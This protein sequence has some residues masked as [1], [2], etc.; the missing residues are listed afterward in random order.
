M[1]TQKLKKP[2]FEGRGKT[3]LLNGSGYLWV[4][5]GR[6]AVYNAFTD[7]WTTRSFDPIVQMRNARTQSIVYD[8]AS[9]TLFIALL[10]RSKS[11][12]VAVS[13]DTGTNSIL[14]ADLR[15]TAELLIVVDGNLHIFGSCSALRPAH[16]MFNTRNRHKEL[17]EYSIPRS[18]TKFHLILH[19]EARKSIIAILG[20]KNGPIF[21]EFSLSTNKWTN[22]WEYSRGGW[23]SSYFWDVANISGLAT[24]CTNDGRYLIS[25]VKNCATKFVVFDLDDHSK[26]PKVKDLTLQADSIWSS[27]SHFRSLL[28]ADDHFEM[29]SYGF[30]RDSQRVL[31]TQVSINGIPEGI[32]ECIAKWLGTKK[33]W[34]YLL[35]TK[36][37]SHWKVA[38]AD[39]VK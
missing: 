38:V 33:E 29:L 12:L 5:N 17:T 3:T 14:S 24:V 19:S 8:R 25:K 2:P 26:D 31:G 20:Y 34:M 9:N 10:R 6:F 32:V 1:N 27:K 23:G 21:G 18:G 22:T 36:G 37:M 13:I 28:M 39:I 35:E 16:L 30:C 7:E 4:S 15:V 11:Q